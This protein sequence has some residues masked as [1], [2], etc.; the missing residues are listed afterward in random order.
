MTHAF[1]PVSRFV[2]THVGRDGLRRLT[3]AQQ[4]R[5]THASR[6]E[7]EDMLAACRERGLAY[8][9]TEAE[10]LTARVDA[11]DCHPDHHDPIGYYV[12]E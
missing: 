10:L 8:V 12:N 1:T 11:V 9:L 6:K 2:I 3:F 5:H 4:G 7:A